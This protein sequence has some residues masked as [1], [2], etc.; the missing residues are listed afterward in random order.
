MKHI[1]IFVI[2][3]I[4]ALTLCYVIVTSANKMCQCPSPRIELSGNGSIT[5]GTA[6]TDTLEPIQ[7]AG[8]I[9]PR[10]N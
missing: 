3:F 6:I 5:Q 4:A 10:N 8:E 9:P 1:A 2:A 7:E